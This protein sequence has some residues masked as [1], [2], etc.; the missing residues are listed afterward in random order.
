MN[1]FAEFRTFIFILACVTGLWAPAGLQA[2]YI[3]G[4]GI[5]EA[6]EDCDLGEDNSDFTRD[7]CR[8]DCR[9]AGCGDGVVDTGEACDDGESSNNWE[10]NHCR[11]DC[12]L[13]RC[14]DGVVDPGLGEECDY[15]AAQDAPANLGCR[16]DCRQC[17]RLDTENLEIE[18]DL[19]LCP[20][21]YTIA[22]YGDDG[23]IVVKHPDVTVDCDGAVLRGSGIGVGIYIKRSN[24][25]TVRNCI[26]TGYGA[27]VT[28]WQSGNVDLKAGTNDF[29]GNVEPV[30]MQESY[31]KP[32]E[33][34]VMSKPEVSV[35]G[36]AVLARQPAPSSDPIAPASKSA[37]VPPRAV[38][39]PKVVRT[40][41]V[42][43]VKATP[44]GTVNRNGAVVSLQLDMQV[45]NVE[46]FAGKRKLG[47]LGQGGAFDISGYVHSSKD[48]TLTFRYYLPGGARHVETLKVK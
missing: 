17:V 6:G 28:A 26:V 27:G 41:A 2:D 20:G 29:A 4:N 23:V 13:P 47:A 44:S 36:A 24:D 37:A 45:E 35:G 40:P 1:H 11:P 32:V 8:P 10:P 7:G 48:G 42:R 21:D 25:V 16:E 12:R 22:D 19:L 43:A 34:P 46:V 3:C 9:K 38:Q 39:A 30:V 15:A 14:G 18:S 31:K 33:R 5:V